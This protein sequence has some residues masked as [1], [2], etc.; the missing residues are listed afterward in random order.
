MQPQNGHLAATSHHEKPDQFSETDTSSIRLSYHHDIHFDT[1][2]FLA[3][4]DL[5]SCLSYRGKGTPRIYQPFIPNFFICFAASH[6]CKVGNVTSQ[7]KSSERVSERRYPDYSI[8]NGRL[9]HSYYPRHHMQA[10]AS[11]CTHFLDMC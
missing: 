2:I 11:F 8:M 1:A 4:H 9:R 3:T 10:L 5:H 7:R 6:W